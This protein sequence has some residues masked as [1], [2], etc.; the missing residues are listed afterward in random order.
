MNRTT[1]IRPV[2]VKRAKQKLLYISER[3]KFLDEHC[4]C[5]RCEL[6][7]ATT[8]HHMANRE[9]NWLNLKRYWVAMCNLCHAACHHSPASNPRYFLSI[10]ET[11]EAH[12]KTLLECG[13]NPDQPIFYVTQ[14]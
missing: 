7:E 12:M 6:V 8:I 5:A 4:L 14:S 13:V 11:Y 3:R 9:G 1:K 10:H 2:A